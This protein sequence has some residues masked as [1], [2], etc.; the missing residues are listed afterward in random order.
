[1]PSL[2]TAVTGPSIATVMMPMA[3]SLE[4]V[5]KSSVPLAATKIGAES[6]TFFITTSLPTEI[7]SAVDIVVGDWGGDF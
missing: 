4:S 1:M 5:M 3:S 2:P 7:N 6:A